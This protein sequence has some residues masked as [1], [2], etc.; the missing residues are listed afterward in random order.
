MPIICNIPIIILF[1]LF[2]YSYYKDADV[3]FL[4]NTIKLLHDKGVTTTHYALLGTDHV[5]LV[6][7]YA[8]YF[9]DI[10]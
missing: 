8:R 3:D 2:V 5:Q 10:V 9:V 1:I 6:T 7:H 4:S